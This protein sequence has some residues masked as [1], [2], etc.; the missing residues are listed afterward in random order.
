MTEVELK[1]LIAKA[2]TRYEEAAQELNAAERKLAVAEGKAKTLY[3]QLA[4][5]Y[6]CASI[7]EAEDYLQELE[8]D[9]AKEQAA[10]AQLESDIQELLSAHQ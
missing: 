3:D 6:E 10:L 7:S 4:Q 1:G 2:R 9:I 5:E 8:E